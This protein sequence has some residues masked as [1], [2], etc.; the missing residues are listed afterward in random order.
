MEET[1]MEET[2]MAEVET[3]LPLL[4]DNPID[5]GRVVDWGYKDIGV[6]I[7]K[8]VLLRRSI[9]QPQFANKAD[10]VR[11]IVDSDVATH[12]HYAHEC[13]NMEDMISDYKKWR[14][15][16]SCRGAYATWRKHLQNTNERQKRT[17][18][19]DER[20]DRFK[21]QVDGKSPCA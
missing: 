17:Q 5:W 11:L 12:H 19:P 10:L 6:A 9:P 18:R 16:E 14:E 3:D 1:E 4:E 15:K 8:I 21:S 13:I 2:G 7:L 20:M